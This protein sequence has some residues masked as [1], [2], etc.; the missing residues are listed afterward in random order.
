MMIAAGLRISGVLEQ[1]AGRRSLTPEDSPGVLPKVEIL[2]AGEKTFSF[3]LHVPHLLRLQPTD[4][5]RARS[6]RR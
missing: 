4:V 2:A 3:S 5:F 6:R 1:A